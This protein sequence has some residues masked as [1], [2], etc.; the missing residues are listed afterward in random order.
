MKSLHIRD[1]DPVVVSR[2]RKLARM[3][4]RSMQGELRAIL[5]EAAKRLPASDEVDPN[6][7]VT[8]NVPGISTWSREELYGD[9]AR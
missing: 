3:H 6:E 9:N 5:A 7:L 8:V 2:L 1:V 4:H